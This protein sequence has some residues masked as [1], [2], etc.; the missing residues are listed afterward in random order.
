MLARG[1]RNDLVRLTWGVRVF[2]D[3]VERI[4]AD[5]THAR[6]GGVRGW[7]LQDDEGAAPACDEARRCAELV[8]FGGDGQQS[9]AHQRKLH[10]GLACGLYKAARSGSGCAVCRVRRGLRVTHFGRDLRVKHL[11]T[12]RS[13]VS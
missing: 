1:A 4:V 7:L 8:G 9:E 6:F 2:A 5:L 3:P 10:L 13:V 11:K 12:S